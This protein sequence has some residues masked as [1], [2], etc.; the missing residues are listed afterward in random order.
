MAG[1]LLPKSRV[2]SDWPGL[3]EANLFEGR[4]LLSTIDARA[5]YAAALSKVFGIDFRNIVS[6]A[7]FGHKL[8][9]VT[10]RIFG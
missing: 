6:K 7:F 5:V 3:N 10:T 2:I 4:D 9:D 8:P 1:G